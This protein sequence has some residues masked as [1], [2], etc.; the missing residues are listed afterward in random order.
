MLMASA[1]LAL[2]LLLLHG[3]KVGSN[4]TY[5][6]GA[7]EYGQLGDGKAGAA[8]AQPLPTALNAPEFAVVKAGLWHTCALTAAGKAY[9]WVICAR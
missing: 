3:V 9:C 6:W 8:H 5:C 2:I 1:L 4:V 7:G